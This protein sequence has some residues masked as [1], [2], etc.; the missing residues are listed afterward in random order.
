MSESKTM[1]NKE[2]I[3]SPP[4]SKQNKKNKAKIQEMT[5][6][7]S[8]LNNFTFDDA[9]HVLT[10][11]GFEISHPKLM[12]NPNQMNLSLK[13]SEDNETNQKVIIKT[14]KTI[15]KKLPRKK[16]E[17]KQ[18]N[19]DENKPPE[20]KPL[21][22]IEVK[23]TQAIEMNKPQSVQT[24]VINS[25]KQTIQQPQVIKFGIG[26]NPLGHKRNPFGL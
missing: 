11:L 5:S 14:K 16:D 7:N 18:E 26:N 10:S 21:P 15:E 22:V 4:L 1:E 6:S 13:K 3:V 19:D 8:Y 25:A 17:K 9:F 20:I 23:K 2:V 12:K 24:Q